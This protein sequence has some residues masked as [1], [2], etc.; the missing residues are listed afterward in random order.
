MKV[1]GDPG[2]YTRIGIV[3]AKI[4]NII[5]P[6]Y[7]SYL[8][9]KNPQ[10]IISTAVIKKYNEFRSVRIE[11]LEWLKLTTSEGRPTRESTER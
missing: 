6:L 1:T 11:A 4:G 9:K 3:L 5:I 7:P 8:I 2:E 10:N